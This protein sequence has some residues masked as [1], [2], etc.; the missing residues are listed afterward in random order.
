MKNHAEWIQIGVLLAA[1]AA[2]AE[3][4]ENLHYAAREIFMPI[5]S[6]VKAAEWRL[7]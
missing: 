5:Y 7:I 4:D 6:G 3:H 2:I 1:K